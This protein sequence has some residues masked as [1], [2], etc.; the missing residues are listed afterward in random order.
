MKQEA[1]AERKALDV[2]VKEI[3]EI[4]RM[5]KGSIKEEAKTNASYAHALRV[6]HKEEL[7]YMAARAKYERAQ[8]DLQVMC[9]CFEFARDTIG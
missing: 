3:A 4:Q 7:E 8:A 1:K 5:Q 6:F 2:A 9:L